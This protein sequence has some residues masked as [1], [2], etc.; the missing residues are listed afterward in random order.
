ML[1]NAKEARLR[2]THRA[3][4]AAWVD[5]SSLPSGQVDPV[6]TVVLSLRPHWPATTL[7]PH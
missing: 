7:G 6:G 5:L 3:L 2:M 4:P 1:W